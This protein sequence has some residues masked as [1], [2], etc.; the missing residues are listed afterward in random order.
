MISISTEVQYIYKHRQIQ[1]LVDFVVSRTNGF[2]YNFLLRFFDIRRKTQFLKVLANHTLLTILSYYPQRATYLVV[3]KISTY[4]RRSRHKKLNH[5][6]NGRKVNSIP[7]R[8][9]LISL[10]PWSNLNFSTASFSKSSNSGPS[11]PGMTSSTLQLISCLGV[12][13]DNGDCHILCARA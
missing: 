3:F 6:R 9:E 8:Q 7:Q 2:I 1:M 5:R 4:P 13:Y 10:L 12:Y 11:L